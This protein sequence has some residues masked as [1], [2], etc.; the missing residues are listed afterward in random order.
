MGNRNPSLPLHLLGEFR[1][2]GVL[3]G[4]GYINQGKVPF[5]TGY[6]DFL[7]KLEGG[8]KVFV[9]G[10]GVRGIV[11]PVTVHV[12]THFDKAFRIHFLSVALFQKIGHLCGEGGVQDFGTE[13][14]VLLGKLFQRLLGHA[15][16]PGQDKYCQ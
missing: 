5:E 13:Y 3:A 11:I 14:L 4:F 9:L 12:P 1:V 10:R 16:W 7:S 2:I 15:Q 6:A 8:E